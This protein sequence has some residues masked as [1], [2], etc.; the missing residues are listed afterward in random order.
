MT[1]SFT[2]RL[3]A[4][5]EAAEGVIY[6]AGKYWPE[7]YECRERIPKYSFSDEACTHIG[8]INPSF[9][10]ELIE[11]YEALEGKLEKAKKFLYNEIESHRYNGAQKFR[12]II[13][14]LE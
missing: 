4:A 14:E 2:E 13:K 3:K 7:V 12:Q 6:D 8:T 10:L 5:K 1:P 11:R 9:T